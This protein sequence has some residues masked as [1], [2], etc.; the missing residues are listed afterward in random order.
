MKNTAILN[1]STLSIFIFLAAS[2]SAVDAATLCP[3][4]TRSLY[5]GVSHGEVTNLQQFLTSTGDFT[6]GSVTKYFG[7]V[8]EKAVQKFQCRE[9]GICSGTPASTGYG[10]VGPGTRAAIQKACS[11]GVESGGGEVESGD[12]E[13]LQV[14]IPPQPNLESAEDLTQTLSDIDSAISQTSPGVTQ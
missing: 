9:M 8:T 6:F 10:R 4:L 13:I 1:I 12:E 11:L 5:K 7:S 14:A 2:V 3:N